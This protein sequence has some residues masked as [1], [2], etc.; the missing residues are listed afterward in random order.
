VRNIFIKKFWPRPYKIF[1]L[2]QF[3]QKTCFWDILSKVFYLLVYTRPS[4][5]KLGI[6]RVKYALQ[7]GIKIIGIGGGR[8]MQ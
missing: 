1:D 5:A 4:A 2:E 3:Y 6:N 7:N 8:P